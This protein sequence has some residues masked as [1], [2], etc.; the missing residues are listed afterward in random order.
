VEKLFAVVT[1]WFVV[2]ASLISLCAIVGDGFNPRNL[3]FAL[4]YVLAWEGVIGALILSAAW[5]VSVF[6]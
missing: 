5:V 1:L 2:T 4:L 6:G 3:C